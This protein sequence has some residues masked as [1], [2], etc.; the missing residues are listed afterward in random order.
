MTNQKLRERIDENLKSQFRGD[1]K[2]VLDKDYELAVYIKNAKSEEDINRCGRWKL[3]SFDKRH[4]GL[5]NE[6]DLNQEILDHYRFI[7][8]EASS[9][10]FMDPL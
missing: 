3:H 5:V 6:M 2:E 8:L 10:I 1:Y 7:V 4:Q 9:E